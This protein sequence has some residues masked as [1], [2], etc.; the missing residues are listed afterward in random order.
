MLF[1][2]FFG[3]FWD[4]WAPEMVEEAG[5]KHLFFAFFFGL[6]WD[7]WALE[8]VGEAAKL[9][10]MVWEAQKKPKTLAFYTFFGLFWDI[11]SARNGRGGC[12]RAENSLGGPKMV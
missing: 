9:P 11:L 4:I 8:M 1:A 2:L 5:R 10:K 7:I 6:F 12:Q 3:L